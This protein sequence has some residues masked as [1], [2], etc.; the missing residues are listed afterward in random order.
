M[1]YSS[2]VFD[3]SIEEILRLLK[4]ETVLDLGAGAGKY[5]QL[6]KNINP[7]IK[8]IAVEI[9]RD[10][11]NKFDLP[12]IYDEV[13]NISVTDFINPEYYD[14]FFDVVMF[15]DI[16][17]HLKKS[18]GVDLLNFL[19]YRCRWIIIKFPHRWLQNSID[20]H[21]SEAHISIWTENDFCSFEK[22]RLYSNDAL[23]L[24]AL[25][26]YLENEISISEIESLI[27]ESE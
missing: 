16:I 14:S 22:T 12:S 19:I 4:P 23:R 5:G 24:I 15:G 21:Q 11:I 8:T 6:A 9:E 25:R 13:W 3:S 27:N 26:G 1:P 18:D 17:E 20:G 2:P 10:Y 7:S